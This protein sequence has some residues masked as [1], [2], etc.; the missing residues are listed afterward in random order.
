[1]ANKQVE[2]SL[3]IIFGGTGDLS[4]R[5]LLPAIGRLAASLSLSDNLH[6]LGVARDT[7][8]DD[9]PFRDLEGQVE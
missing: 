5:K 2:P 6:V 3:F 8:Q 4:R 1:M 9:A 7:R